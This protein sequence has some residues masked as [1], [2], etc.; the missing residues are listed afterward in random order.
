MIS[1][2]RKSSKWKGNWQNRLRQEEKM[3]RPNSKLKRKDCNRRQKDKLK[4]P[5]R[6]YR[7]KGFN[8]RSMWSNKI[9]KHRKKPRLRGKRLRG[10]LRNSNVRRRNL[11]SLKGKD[12]KMRKRLKRKNL[13]FREKKKSK[14]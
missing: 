2:K 13:D 11:K 8:D 10:L 5:A 1:Y 9:E 14:K 4:R 12:W 6:S 7:S 3:M